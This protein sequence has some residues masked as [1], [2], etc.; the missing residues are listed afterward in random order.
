[1]HNGFVRGL[2]CV[3]RRD[4]MALL[5]LRDAAPQLSGLPALVTAAFPGRFSFTLSPSGEV[6]IVL[7]ETELDAGLSALPPAMTVRIL[8]DLTAIRAAGVCMSAAESKARRICA[9]LARA[10]IPLYAFSLCDL[11]LSFTVATADADRAIDL[12]CAAVPLSD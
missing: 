7:P 10:G 3:E 5:L 1:M 2:R 6:S 8:R 9:H 4:G 11:A 12:I